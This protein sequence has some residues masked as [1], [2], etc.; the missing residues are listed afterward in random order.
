[1]DCR[2]HS[3]QPSNHRMN[4]SLLLAHLPRMTAVDSFVCESIAP[5]PP[6]THSSSTTVLPCRRARRIGRLRQLM[7]IACSRIM[8][9]LF[10]VPMR[11]FRSNVCTREFWCNSD[12]SAYIALSHF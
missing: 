3:K 11:T 1:P 8:P 5:F 9:I 10:I 2:L 4:L 6:F 7:K 12:D